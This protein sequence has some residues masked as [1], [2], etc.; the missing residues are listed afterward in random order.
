MPNWPWLVAQ[1]AEPLIRR[2][3]PATRAKVLLA[4]GAVVVLGVTM[5][6][7]IW[8][9]G[10]ATRRYMGSCEPKPSA[11]PGVQQDDWARTPIVPPIEESPGSDEA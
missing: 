6:V 1:Q 4:L 10:R 2:L 11:R 5:I 3:D 7:L 9:T 8:L